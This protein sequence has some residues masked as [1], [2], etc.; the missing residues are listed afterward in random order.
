MNSPIVPPYYVMFMCVWVYTRHYI[1]L[2]LLFSVMP[3]GHIPFTNIE[4]GQF[5]T[6]GPYGINWETHQYKGQLASCIAFTLMGALQAVNIFWF[7]L[8][9]RILLRFANGIVKDERSDDEEEEEEEVI[10]KADD[11]KTNGR[12]TKSEPNMT[13]NGKPVTANGSAKHAANGSN[14]HVTKRKA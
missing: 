13:I 11:Q 2:R 3:A 14:G 4:T 7:V 12:V 9:I 6:V 8:I 10:A 5:S 1:N